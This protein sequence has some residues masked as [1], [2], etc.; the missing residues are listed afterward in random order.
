MVYSAIKRNPARDGNR[1]DLER[2]KDEAIGME[3][4]LNG[5]SHATLCAVARD[6]ET[7]LRETESAGARLSSS[8]VILTDFQG[9]AI[10][11]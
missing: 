8:F 9:W 3:P 1:N 7:G 6:V 10:G 5:I 4:W 11:I 2:D